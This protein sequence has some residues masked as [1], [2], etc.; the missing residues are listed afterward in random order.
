VPSHIPCCGACYELSGVSARMLTP[1]DAPLMPHER[2]RPAMLPPRSSASRGRSLRSPVSAD[3]NEPRYA[4]DTRRAVILPVTLVSPAYAH[5]SHFCDQAVVSGAPVMHTLSDEF[6]L[7]TVV[8]PFVGRSQDRQSS[9]PWLP[10]HPTRLVSRGA[11]DNLREV[12]PNKRSAA[13][14]QD[15]MIPSRFFEMMASSEDS[16]IAAR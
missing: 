10:V 12:Q 2:R 8:I 6:R 13:E 9:R 16:M 1:S 3:A 15:W 4:K 5:H 11:L 14:L 7:R